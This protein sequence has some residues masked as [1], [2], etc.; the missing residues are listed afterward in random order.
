MEDMQKRSN[1]MYSQSAS[2]VMRLLSWPAFFLLSQRKRVGATEEAFHEAR[3][4]RPRT[5]IWTD[6][7]D[8]IAFLGIYSDGSGSIDR[9]EF[10]QIPQIANNPL[11]SRLIAIFDEE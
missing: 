1:C 5:H 2:L 10:L 3:Q 4:V 11:A 7:E 9:E 8:L 6:H